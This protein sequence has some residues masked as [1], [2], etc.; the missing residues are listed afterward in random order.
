M[1]CLK[2]FL[3]IT[4]LNL[5]ALVP[6]FGLAGDLERPSLAMPA[7]TP[8]TFR[9][10]LM[11]AISE[12]ELNFLDGHFVNGSTTLHYGGSTEALN[13]LIARLSG[14]DGVRVWITFV[15]EP[16]GPAWTL[17]HNAW[18]DAGGIALQINI[19]AATLKLEQLG[20]TIAG[21]SKGR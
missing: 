18:A 12:K 2:R 21:A 13:R 17:S 1:N 15:K 4:F 11:A 5:V 10:N 16:G 3:C 7:S 9:T 6:A 19:A 20:I 14:M 8:E